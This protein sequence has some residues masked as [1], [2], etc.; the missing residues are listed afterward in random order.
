MAVNKRPKKNC[1]TA[2]TQGME[3]KGS[4]GNSGGQIKCLEAETWEDLLP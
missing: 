3:T 1:K 2:Y 4:K